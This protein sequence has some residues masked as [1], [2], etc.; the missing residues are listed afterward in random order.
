MDVQAATPAYVT[1]A[2]ELRETIRTMT[3]GARFPTERE[4]AA[5]SG[6]ARATVRKSL[7]LLERDGLIVR[8]QGSG[9]FVAPTRHILDGDFLLGFSAELQAQGGTIS[10]R[11]LS[12]GTRPATPAVARQL[13]LAED[14]EIVELRRI[15]L[16]DDEPASL[17]TASLPAARFRSLVDLD[18]RNRSLYETVRQMGI[19]PATGTETLTATALDGFTAYTLKVDSSAPALRCDRVAYDMHGTPIEAVVTFLR[20]DRI[21]IR[22]SMSLVAKD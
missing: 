13:E 7:T 4:V 11:L 5:S 1:L 14:A 10:S 6:L 19:V 3:P 22:T 21:A 12:I 2:E 15:R 17:E 8:R 20:A 16:I 9:T 18:W